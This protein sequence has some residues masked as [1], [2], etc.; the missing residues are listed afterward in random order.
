MDDQKLHEIDTALAT[1]NAKLDERCATHFG[2]IKQVCED[3]LAL[4]ERVHKLETK[5]GVLW[6][7]GGLLIALILLF[8]K[9]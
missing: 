6:A 8:I 1:L 7:G 4:K 3:N 2:K 9:G 5:M